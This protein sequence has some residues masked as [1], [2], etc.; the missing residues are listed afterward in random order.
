MSRLNCACSPENLRLGKAID[1]FEKA[2]RVVVGIR[3]DAK[4]ELLAALFAPFTGQVIFMRTESA[5]MVKH[6]L[7]AYLALSISFINEVG[8]LCELTGADAKEVSAGLKS[9]VRIGPKAYLQAG[10]A[11]AG[12][13]LAR[14]VV[15]LTKLA[16]MRGETLAVI[17]AIKVSNDH[18]RHWA[19]RKLEMRFGDLKGKIILVLG[20]TYT[21]NTDTL[22]RS[23][24][25][26]LCAALI[27][28]GATVRVFDPVVKSLP[29]E[30][31]RVTLVPDI[32]S[33]MIGADAVVV[34]TEWPQFLEADWAAM[35]T[36]MRQPVVLDPNG[37]LDKKLK[38]MTGLEHFAVGRA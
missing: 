36:K 14:D 3:S 6:A 21:I 34:C 18:H 29:L 38:G 23:V 19:L 24:A 2:D 1:A 13:T 5:E 28:S 22:R 4:K 31:N 35:V 11:F 37:F 15:T 17:P 12:G 27:Q 10:G 9:D 32:A 26:E 16:E 8:R 25:V 20:L 7:N 33:A 30:I